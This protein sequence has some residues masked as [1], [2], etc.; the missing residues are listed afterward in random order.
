MGKIVL[1]SRCATIW[2]K[3]GGIDEDGFR[4]FLQR[5]VDSSHGVYMAS[6]GSGEGNALTPT[7]LATVFRIGVETCKGKVPCRANLPESHTARDTIALAKIAVEAGVDV[8]NIYGPASWHGY[9]ATDEEYFSYFD[10]V[11]AEIKHPV[12]L[13]PNP[14]TGY[15]P[16]ASVIA[17]ICHKYPQ[18][19]TVN[20]SGQSDDIYLVNLLDAMKR[21]IEI[22]VP[23]PGSANTLALGAT[24]LLGAQANLIPKT[25]RD[26]ID[27]YE[28]G[29]LT[30]ANKVY[31]DMKRV[32]Q[33]VKRWQPSTPRWIK[34]ALKAFKLPGW[35]G[36]VR[37]PYVLPDD[38]ELARF[39]D[40]A[41]R[42]DVPE[43]NE[44]ARAAGVM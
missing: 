44:M 35:E 39:I 1:I 23:W 22:Y 15:A 9:R 21:D 34:L 11:F 6:G 19:T 38:T 36:G 31:G 12:A 25:F 17:D 30:E 16:A 2:D 37:E 20:L 41:L 27:L 33:F 24:G 32:A 18:V 7:E 43:I 40:G 5:F 13:N 26:Y 10:R 3:A 4:R 8:I 28:A 29:K 14:T 42:L